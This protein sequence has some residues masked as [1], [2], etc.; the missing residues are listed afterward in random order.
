[1]QNVPDVCRAI[2]TIPAGFI[3][4][5]FIIYWSGFETLWKLGVSYWVFVL[6][7]RTFDEKKRDAIDTD[8]ITPTTDCVSESL[9]ALDKRWKEG[10]FR[11]VMPD[12]RKRVHS[13]ETFLVAGDR[14]AIGSSSSAASIIRMPRRATTGRAAT[15]RAARA[16]G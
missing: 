12:F 10:A 4:A 13:G 15:T 16:R 14:F 3:I 9:D 6:Q 1:M 7:R 11:H 5:N 8:Q 2:S